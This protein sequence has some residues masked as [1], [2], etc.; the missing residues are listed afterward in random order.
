VSWRIMNLTE[1]REL[2]E[3]EMH[4][5]APEAE[6]QVDW[7]SLARQLGAHRFLL[8][9]IISTHCARRLFASTNGTRRVSS[10]IFES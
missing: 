4:L 7:A 6:Q 1:G 2:S 3:D 10:E 5:W 9:A 8:P